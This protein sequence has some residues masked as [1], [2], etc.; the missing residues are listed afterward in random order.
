MPLIELVNNLA[1][2]P[3]YYGGT[4]NFIQKKIPFGSDQPGGL[5]SGEP[6]IQFPLP[7]NAAPTTRDYYRNNIS[8]LDFPM[9]GSTLDYL[10]QGIVV[11]KAAEYD[12]RR[13]NKFLK[14]NP[15][16]Y[17]FIAKQVGLQ[18]TNPKMEVGTQ[19]NINA[20]DTNLRFFGVLENTRIYNKGANTLT[21][22]KLSGTGIHVDRH[23]LVPYNPPSTL[24]ERVVTAANR[25]PPPGG[26]AGDNNRLVSLLK[27]KIYEQPRTLEA[28]GNLLRLGIPRNQN[29]LFQY[30]GGP[31]SSYGLGQTTIPRFYNNNGLYQRNGVAP[32]YDPILPSDI[33]PATGAAAIKGTS[34]QNILQGV[35]N[36]GTT[37]LSRRPGYFGTEAI[38]NEFPNRNRLVVLQKQ[39]L[40]VSDLG[41]SPIYGQDAVKGR[42]GDDNTFIYKYSLNGTPQ[43]DVTLQRAVYTDASTDLEKE[44]N[45]SS[46]KTNN[47]KAFNYNMLYNAVSAR[48]KG[49]IDTDFRD[50]VNI[51]YRLSPEPTAPTYNKQLPASVYDTTARNRRGD[52]TESDPVSKQLPFLTSTPP[53]ELP[54]DLIQCRFEPVEY[55]NT[56]PVTTQDITLMF[57]AYITNLSDNSQ[58]D[59]S[60]FRYTGRGENFYIYN[61]FTRGI[62]FNLKIAA[63]AKED[64]VPLYTKFNYLKSQLYPDYNSAGFMRSPLMKLTIGNYLYR[65]PGFLT[66]IGT[67]IEES[68]PWDIDAQV[69]TILSLSCQFTPIHNFLPRRAF[70][71]FDSQTKV[72]TST[73][74]NFVNYG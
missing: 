18:L 73:V 14:S 15:K 22:I 30:T 48:N 46:F 34:L 8:G 38:N 1:N 21:Q 65:Q 63:M 44:V 26:V 25:I 20:E 69:P 35:I 70:S 67:T 42:T 2:F 43:E 3:Y 50:Q 32:L 62:S 10:A 7:E 4:G 11:P 9:R 59:Y 55:N 74:P 23:G 60:S 17:T 47:A 13:I 33:D 19:A 49:Y 6:Y 57:R 39:L 36:T 12:T 68:T 56:N 40:R 31:G 64:L 45:R 5:S 66:N 28:R 54:E 58:G 16:G 51:A 24:Y 29:I 72:V 52:S 53:D 61:G 71:T 37:P 27:S 41:Q